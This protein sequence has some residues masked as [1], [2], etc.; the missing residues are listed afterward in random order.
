MGSV[1]CRCG[2]QIRTSAR[3]GTEV[4][5]P[6]CETWLT[7]VDK[8]LDP[9]RAMDEKRIGSDPGVLLRRTQ[10]S[11][12]SE[13]IGGDDDRQATIGIGRILIVSL[14]AAIPVALVLWVYFGFASRSKNLTRID[15]SDSLRTAEIR[16]LGWGQ[17]DWKDKFEVYPKGAQI[18]QIATKIADT[19]MLL[20]P[21]RFWEQLDVSAF[22]KNVLSPDGSLVAYQEKTPIKQILD[23]LKTIPLDAVSETDLIGACKWDVIGVHPGPE[24]E[25]IGVLIRYFNEPIELSKFVMSEA[26]ISEMSKMLSMEEYFNVAKDLY[27]RRSGK[28]VKR[29][30]F[31]QQRGM[32]EQ[33]YESIFTPYFG[34]MVLIFKTSSSGV[35]WSDMVAIPS[36]VRLSRAC[37]TML[38]KD[39]YSFRKRVSV[40][41]QRA[42][43]GRTPEGMID[44]FGEYN[45]LDEQ[46]FGR[47][48]VSGDTKPDGETVARI[49]RA[50]PS[51]SSSRSK[52]LVSVALAATSNYGRLKESVSAFRKIHPKDIGVDALLLSI[53]LRHHSSTRSGMTFGDFGEVFVD[54]ADRLYARHKDPL[55]F[56]IK[57]RIYWS[58]G[59]RQQS[60]EQLALAER[61]G[62]A[63]AFY[64][65]RRIESS[66]ENNNKAEALSYL[67]KFSTFWLGQPGVV[68]ETDPNSSLK[69][70]HRTWGN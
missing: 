67:S 18:K 66:L 69:R 10:A 58:H 68:L 22:E 28:G 61:L 6:R 21:G 53:W 19:G 17:I 47:E 31:A 44:I 13:K 1:I 32:Q 49:E 20:D 3:S 14:M 8:V 43:E 35:L 41:P 39:W 50:I 2:Q 56:D 12:P 60:D 59:Q 25:S 37:G 40:E 5:C 42:P 16:S 70:L 46:S 7:V 24:P 26:W 63:S 54:A 52:E 11:D 36:E 23:G 33:V 30:D 55:L 34:Y 64:F 38:Q 65:Q 29:G 4:Q 57:A 51:I 15:K 9:D 27:A 45:S 48:L 62:N